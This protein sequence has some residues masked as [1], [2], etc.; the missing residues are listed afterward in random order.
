MSEDLHGLVFK[1]LAAI[2]VV[3]GVLFSSVAV[4]QT[5]GQIAQ[6]SYA[7]PM[8]HQ[9]GRGLFVAAGTGQKAPEGAE[10]LFVTPSGL[11][12]EGGLPELAGETA[13]IEARLKGK[14]VSAADL[15]AAA[16]DLEAAYARAGYLLARVSLPK[17]TIVDGARLKLVVTDGY[18]AAVD[19]SALPDNVAR[20]VKAVLIPIIGKHWPTRRDLERSLLLAGDTPGVVLR[21]TLKA[22][23]EPGQTLVVLD[24]AYESVTAFAAFDNAV[25]DPLGGYAANFGV[26][27]NNLL[28]L[29]EVVY[30]RLSGFLGFGDQGIVSNDPRNRQI[31][32]GVTVPLGA[33]GLWLNLEGIESRTHPTSSLS[34]TIPDVYQRLSARLGYDWLRGRDVNLSSTLGLDL[35]TENQ[36]FDIAGLRSPFTS[37]VLRVLRLGLSGDG[38][39]PSGGH[40]TGRAAASFGLDAFGARQPTASLPLSRDGAGPDFIRLDASLSY[41]KSFHNRLE[42]LLRTKAQTSFGKPLPASEQ[43]GLTGSD[44][45][46]GFASGAI[47]GDSGAVVRGELRYPIAVPLMPDFNGVAVPYVFA[48]AGISGL[49]QP[50]AVERA[51]TTATSFGA[52][53]RF[54]L[55]KR[56]SPKATSLALEYAHGDA[57]GTDGQERLNFSVSTQF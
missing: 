11:V 40:V 23:A 57:T 12:V 49:E 2:L 18:I 46:S 54:G 1:P 22:G 44:Y 36:A 53:I 51:V 41:V 8:A 21:S 10:A 37:D 35:V 32:G 39:D 5:A 33:N 24:G 52:G 4:A 42:L 45:L 28:G 50:T 17:Q 3:C 26:D 20:R 55:S 15:F 47:Q 56:A 14:R 13:S 43:I 6:P 38:Y 7:P 25:S 48:A 31:A 16:A 30:A 19:T 27:F 34:Y 29:G 9:A